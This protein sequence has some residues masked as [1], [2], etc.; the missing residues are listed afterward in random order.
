MSIHGLEGK[1]V[2]IYIDGFPLNSPDGSFDINDIP[3]DAIKYIEIYKG[4]V[5]AEYGSTGHTSVCRN[6]RY[7]PY[8]SDDAYINAG[9]SCLYIDADSL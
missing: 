7:F 5:P 3:I 9:Y 6:H 8:A 2:A 4:I 1:R